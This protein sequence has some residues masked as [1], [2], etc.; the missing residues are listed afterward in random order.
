MVATRVAAV[1]WPGPSILEPEPHVTATTPQ[2][3]QENLEAAYVAWGLE[4]PRARSAE[5]FAEALRGLEEAKCAVQAAEALPPGGLLLVDGALSGL[6]PGP[7]A[8]AD[9]ILAAAKRAGAVAIGVAKRST[10]E[11]GGL[12]LATA[13]Q[14]SG[15]PGTWAVEVQDGVFVARLHARSRHAFRIDASEFAKVARLLPLCRDAVYTGYPYPLALAHN[16]VAL[17]HAHA[18]E[19]AR[20]LWVEVRRVGGPEAAALLADFHE[21]LDRNT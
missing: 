10:L 18:R 4:A 2:A 8:L 12:P 17:T 21:V 6:P 19:L 5:A 16:A 15:P 20:R 11:Q 14:Q 7:Q 13:L 3:A 1:T 9:R